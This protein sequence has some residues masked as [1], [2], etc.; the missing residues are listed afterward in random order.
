MSSA[1]HVATLA[2]IAIVVLTV[3]FNLVGDA[4]RDHLDPRMRNDA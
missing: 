1:P 3:G 2:G 4:V